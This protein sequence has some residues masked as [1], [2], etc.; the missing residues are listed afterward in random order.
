MFTNGSSFDMKKIF[1]TS[2]KEGYFSPDRNYLLY[3]SRSDVS[4]YRVLK[5]HY[6]NYCFINFKL[7]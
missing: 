4:K 6:Y 5:L 7:P 3:G 1:A 2:E